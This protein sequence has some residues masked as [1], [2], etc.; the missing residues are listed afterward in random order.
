M[1]KDPLLQ[2]MMIKRLILVKEGQFRA[3]FLA[4]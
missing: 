2:M 1:E 4:R 3:R